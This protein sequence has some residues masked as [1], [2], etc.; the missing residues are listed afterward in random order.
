MFSRLVEEYLPFT[1]TEERLEVGKEGILNTPWVRQ[2]A[3]GAAS[4]RLSSGR[5]LCSQLPGL[6][7]TAGAIT[8]PYC[9]R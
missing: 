4:S 9:Q 3:T 1:W 5:C 2:A 8:G 6:C 7:H